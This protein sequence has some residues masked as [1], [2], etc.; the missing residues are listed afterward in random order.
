MGIRRATVSFILKWVLNSLCKVNCHE[1]VKALEKNEPMILAINHINFLEVPLYVAHG[2]P[3]YI[4]GIAKTETWDSSIF[5]FIFNTYNAIPINRSSA[6]SDV[7]KRVRKAVDDGFFVIVAP[8]GTRSKNGVLGKGKAGILYLANDTKIPV[9]PVVHFGG[10]KLGD[11]LRR[12]RR[13]SFYFKAGK[14]FRINFNE[15]P[16][17]ETRDGMTNEVMGQMAK[18]LPKELRGIYAEQA[19]RADSECKYLEFI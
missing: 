15:R 19:E 17:R 16:N 10:E 5:A 8:E 1:L 18:L 6:F 13:T 11:N 4:T 9:L 3:H 14:P 2:Y 12:F 7:F